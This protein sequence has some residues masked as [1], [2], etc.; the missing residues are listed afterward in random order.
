MFIHNCCKVTNLELLL[1]VGHSALESICEV[2]GVLPVSDEEHQRLKRRRSVGDLGLK[3]KY[4][5]GLRSRKRRS[6]VVVVEGQA[7]V[8]RE[9]LQ[10]L[11]VVLLDVHADVV[12]LN[13]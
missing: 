3:E 12:D 7:S 6:A 11:K 4:L 8:L 1:Q 10:V 13:V 2:V 5:E 9:E